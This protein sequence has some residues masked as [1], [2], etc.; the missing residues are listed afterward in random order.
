[1]TPI[2]GKN[3][4]MTDAWKTKTILLVVVGVLA[5]GMFHAYGAYTFN[6]NPWRAVV[7]MACVLGFL[8]FWGLMLWNRGRRSRL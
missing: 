6:H 8:S 2:K 3:A 5:W 7:V 1:M 4:I